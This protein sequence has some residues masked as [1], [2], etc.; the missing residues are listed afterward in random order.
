MT[1]QKVSIKRPYE[2]YHYSN[3]TSGS[4]VEGTEQPGIEITVEYATGSEDVA[5]RGFSEAVAAM[6]KVL[7]EDTDDV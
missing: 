4:H 2:G 5:R 3:P 1:M 6:M 7:Q